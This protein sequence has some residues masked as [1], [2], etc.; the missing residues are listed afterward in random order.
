MFERYFNDPSLDV[1]AE[2]DRLAARGREIVQAA[3]QLMMSVDIEADG[4]PGYGSI[5]SIGAASP[6]DEEFYVELKP[7]S[8][9]FV[10]H[11]QKFCEE[12]GL[13][14]DRLI[15][16]GVESTEGL[17]QFVDWT[18]GIAQRVDKKTAVVGV[19][20]GFESEFLTLECVKAGITNPYDL[21]PIDL[22]S[23]IM[24]IIGKWDWKATQK[25]NLPA[26]FKPE[27][28]FTHNAL[29]DAIYQQQEHF[30][31]AALAEE[32]HGR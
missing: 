24:G 1:R 18:N 17:Q 32:L 14:R 31:A 25:T 20:P 2:H 5:A 12:H 19:N 13:G 22:K 16:E 9:L 29:E 10:P 28:D 30:V 27:G 21:A 4:R 6:Y 23:L 8:D 11:Q 3:P 7:G 26:I 15:K